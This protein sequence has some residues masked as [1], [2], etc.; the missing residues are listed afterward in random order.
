MKHEKSFKKLQIQNKKQVMIIATILVVLVS[1]GMLY[2]SPI[3]SPIQ[4]AG[5]DDDGFKTQY[6]IQNLRGDTVD[7]WAS[8]RIPVDA[9]F[10]IHL[11]DSK[12]ATPDKVNAIVSVIMSDKEIKID[13]NLMHKGPAGTTS[14]Y[15]EGWHGALNSITSDT[16]FNI[17]KNLHFHVDNGESTGNIVIMLTDMSSPDGY[18]GYTNSIVDEANHQI[19]KSTITIYDVNKLSIE[20][21]KTILRHELG[22]GFGLAHSTALEDLMYPVITTYY[23][24]ISDCDLDAISH[25]YDGGGDSSNVVCEK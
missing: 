14:V 11:L 10:H 2:L 15:Y 16:K 24:Y 19:L 21:L 5:V 17:V 3:I 25:L 18:S 23:P 6:L 7:T 9:P 22:H 1:G 13:D 4:F 8:W 12:F 20:N